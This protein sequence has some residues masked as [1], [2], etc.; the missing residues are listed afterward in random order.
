MTDSSIIDD[1]TS[2]GAAS[3]GGFEFQAQVAAWFMVR[4]LAEETGTLG[5]GIGE[6]YPVSVRCETEAPVDDI[7]IETSA[8][9]L[10]FVQAKRTLTADS[11]EGSAFAGVMEQFARQWL[12]SKSGSGQRS[13][14]RPLDT[15]R[16]RL[17]LTVGREASGSIR[18]NLRDALRRLP[19]QAD[20]SESWDTLVAKA[21]KSIKERK[22]FEVAINHLRAAWS[23]LTGTEPAV[24]ELVSLLQLVQIQEL[25]LED[26]AESNRST[27]ELLKSSVLRDTAQ[28]AAAWST[29][30]Q[31]GL[32]LSSQQGGIQ[33]NGLVR[34]LWSSGLLVMAAPRFQRDIAALKAF[35]KRTRLILKD[36]AEISGQRITRQCS[37]ALRE[38]ANLGSVVVVGEPGSGK[39]GALVALVEELA[40]SEDVVFLAV[41]HLN[42]HAQRDLRAEMSLEHDLSDVLAAWSG[43]SRGFLVIDAFDAAR[44][45]FSAGL[46]LD[47]LTLIS[48]DAPR[49]HVVVSI[50][51]YDLRH[52]ERLAALFKGKPPSASF[53]NSGFLS[54]RHVAVP[55]LDEQELVDFADK[56][57]SL[58]AILRNPSPDLLELL[59][60]PFNLRLV[61]DLMDHGVTV[62]SL[63]PVTAQIE[64]LDRYFKL[65]VVESD[66]DNL[67]EEREETVRQIALSMVT[68]RRLRAS[69]ASVADMSLRK[70]L[71]TLLSNG[72]LREWTN[73]GIGEPDRQTLVFAHNV[74]FDYA[75]ERLI[76]PSEPNALL[77]WLT[78][79]LDL[80]LAVRL[81]LAMRFERLWRQAENREQFW[82]HCFLFA[83]SPELSEIAKLVPPEVASR[84]IRID[85][86]FQLLMRHCAARGGVA[87]RVADH[88]VGSRL[89]S[90]TEVGLEPWGEFA[91][92]VAPYVPGTALQLLE[93]LLQYDRQG[94]RCHL[95]VV[96]RAARAVFDASRAEE[97]PRRGLVGRGIQL[98]AQTFASN[99]NESSVRLRRVI[100]PENLRLRGY[101]DLF[102]LADS[103]PSILPHDLDLVVEIYRMGFRAPDRSDE[104]T[105]MSSGRILQLV[106]TRRQDY[107]MGL[108]ELT[109]N[110]PSVLE[111][112]PVHGTLAL[113]SALDGYIPQAHN[114]DSTEMRFAFRGTEARIQQDYSAIW[115]APGIQSHDE[116]GELLH[117]FENWLRQ[118]SKEPAALESVVDVVAHHGKWACLWRAL[119]SSAARGGEMRRLMSPLVKQPMFF[120]LMDTRHAT[121]ELLKI[122]FPVASREERIAIEESILSVTGEGSD[123]IRARMLACL[124]QESIVTSEARALQAALRSADALPDNEPVFGFRSYSGLV[125]PEDHL[126]IQGVD[127]ARKANS[128]LLAATK[129]VIAL[130]EQLRST[131]V[132]HVDTNEA[133]RRIAEIRAA[134][135]ESVEARADAA[136]VDHARAYLAELARL[137]VEH[138]S[139]EVDSDAFQL[140]REVLITFA[141]EPVQEPSAEEVAQFDRFQSWGR[142]SV[143]ID[144]AAGLLAIAGKMTLHSS[145]ILSLVGDLAHNQWPSVRFLVISEIVKLFRVD[146]GLMW[147]LVETSAANEAS[148]G[149]LKA[150]LASLS[151]LARVDSKRAANAVVGILDRTVD[152]GE[153]YAEVTELA[154][155]LITELFVWRNE[156]IAAKRVQIFTTKL[157]VPS[158][159]TIVF[160][161]KA[162]L[163]FAGNGDSS[164]AKAVRER[165][166]ST[167]E[168]LIRAVSDELRV[169][170]DMSALNAEQQVWASRLVDVI[171][172]AALHL[173]AIFDLDKFVSRDEPAVQED[174]RREVYLRLGGALDCMSEVAHPRAA[175][176]IVEALAGCVDF[177]RTGVFLRLH[178]V[179]ANASKFGF[180][181]ESMVAD[182]ITKI[183]ER[184]LSE[185]RDLF[186]ENVEA[187]KA[188]VAILDVFVREGWRAA[189][190][191]TYRLDDVLR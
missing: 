109:K 13:W 125:T 19:S 72:V 102:W 32:A 174:I 99:P 191:L 134:L 4:L 144:S 184:Y 15:Q 5:L 78:R 143:H 131:E 79:E 73:N 145:E 187:R 137:L 7:L 166:A 98:V 177:D 9:G 10:V 186:L 101:E 58:A 83:E 139:P 179:V 75:V 48:A 118:H 158:L 154:V 40:A 29:L 183:V 92:Q 74:L 76:L 157:G 84:R 140:S 61:A 138:L 160:H 108:Y 64:L 126:E 24:Q 52:S 176:H 21:T 133:I 26:G 135:G 116:T 31:L 28:A 91:A 36:L 178:R 77:A 57:P 8:S 22:V 123:R 163:I 3:A 25:A 38:A 59:R 155:G 90:N 53:T 182:E 172:A 115:D 103:I 43:S 164:Q 37:A 47:L 80:G 100:E 85:A 27:I 189:R 55:R 165:A 65:R 81:S 18:E 41:D 122:A 67:G 94:A 56:I 96:G 153:R 132:V 114:L 50:R 20:P 14:E 152:S 93:A 16:D 63:A 167:L 44:G 175:H 1:S 117:A 12:A 49:W 39:S 86:D 170:L 66:S 95:D 180:Q 70:T 128:D 112:S 124:E 168:Q 62:D 120:T 151:Q 121:A 54:L 110:F 159:K 33:R 156:D 162:A 142:P 45:E 148:A 147:Q 17:V 129:P 173:S 130:A 2:G 69:R 190:K 51:E 35:S 88:V 169:L 111:R 11:K 136:T 6:A 181:S 30:V 82:S 105:D 171:D 97:I 107:G 141:R 46:L 104:Q 119:L 113:I 185:H 150:T 60:N 87:P 149:V 34:H 89:T 106:S 71:P 23:R 42:A 161:V 188:L 127:V 68:V 146:P